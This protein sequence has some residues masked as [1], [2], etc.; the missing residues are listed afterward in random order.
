MSDTFRTIKDRPIFWTDMDGITHRCEG[1]NVH[2]GIRLLWT[3]CKRDV[4]AGNAY[5]PGDW[6]GVTCPACISSARIER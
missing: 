4:P 3:D 5:L 6:D 1:A 2:P